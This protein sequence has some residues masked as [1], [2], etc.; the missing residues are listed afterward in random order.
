V[1]TTQ[2]IIAFGVCGLITYFALKLMGVMEVRPVEDATIKRGKF[3]IKGGA[4]HQ[5]E[6][7]ADDAENFDLKK[8]A[9]KGNPSGPYYPPT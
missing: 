7:N 9:N 6:S 5:G 1:T 8:D 2:T 3:Y 4:V